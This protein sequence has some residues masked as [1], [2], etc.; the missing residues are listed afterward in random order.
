MS[1]IAEGQDVAERGEAGF[2]GQQLSGIPISQENSHFHHY[3]LVKE[4]SDTM[5]VAATGYVDAFWRPSAWYL[6]N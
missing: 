1:I 5:L 3:W 6:N 4:A 2:T